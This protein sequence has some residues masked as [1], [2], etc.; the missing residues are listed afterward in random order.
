MFFTTRLARLVQPNPN[1]RRP[2]QLRAAATTI[3]SQD[4]NAPFA[5][6]P[7]R[8]PLLHANQ[9]GLKPRRIDRVATIMA[10]SIR[11]EID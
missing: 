7:Y 1:A 4:T 8:T 5:R 11:Y 10:W 3:T 2:R 9:F 6:C